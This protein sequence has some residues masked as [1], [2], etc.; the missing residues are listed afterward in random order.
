MNECLQFNLTSNIMDCYYQNP[1]NFVIDNWI[2]CLFI[3]IVFI[4]IWI[5]LNL[6]RC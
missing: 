6:D 1:F 4:I 3:L 2:G 5:M